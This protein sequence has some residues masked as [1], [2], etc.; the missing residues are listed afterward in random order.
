[1]RYLHHFVPCILTAGTTQKRLLYS[2]IYR[3][4]GCAALP[5][6]FHRGVQY[7]EQLSVC[8]SGFP[9]ASFPLS[10]LQC[11]VVIQLK[12]NAHL[13]PTCV[14]CAVVPWLLVIYYVCSLCVWISVCVYILQREA[15]CVSHCPLSRH[16]PPPPAHPLRA[17]Q[18]SAHLILE[19]VE[20]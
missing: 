4:Y 9:I 6:L 14:G 17:L 11:D 16:P 1:M 12:V 18:S 3:I 5:G 13:M 2:V 20:L 15:V 10:Q 7:T 8:L 19:S